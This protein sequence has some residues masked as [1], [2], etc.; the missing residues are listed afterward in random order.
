MLQ[1]HFRRVLRWLPHCVALAAVASACSDTSDSTGAHLKSPPT[2]SFAIVYDGQ[3]NAADSYVAE[4]V[5][6]YESTVLQ[7][8]TPTYDPSG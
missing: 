2:P 7:F 6:S 5:S 4:D 1:K 8:S 3:I